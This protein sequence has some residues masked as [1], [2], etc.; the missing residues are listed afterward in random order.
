M[1][2]VQPPVPPSPGI[3]LLAFRGKPPNRTIAM[4]WRRSSAMADFLLKL[5]AQFGA[6]PHELLQY[7]PTFANTKTAKPAKRRMGKTSR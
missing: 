2:A 1:L 7:P 6:P 5:A 4:V 3:H